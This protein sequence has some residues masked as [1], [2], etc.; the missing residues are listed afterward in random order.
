MASIFPPDIKSGLL[1]WL[2]HC[3]GLKTTFEDLLKKIK[4]R[5]CDQNPEKTKMVK[6]I[7]LIL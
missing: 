6:T 2:K 4:I 1:M 3:C 7:F 5:D